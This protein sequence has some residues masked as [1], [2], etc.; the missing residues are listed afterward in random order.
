MPSRIFWITHT[1]AKKSSPTTNVMPRTILIHMPAKKPRFAGLAFFA[2]S[3]VVGASATRGVAPVLAVAAAAVSDAPGACSLFFAIA[4]L[5]LG[6]PGFEGFP[7]TKA[8]RLPNHERLPGVLLR[9]FGAE[10]I[11]PTPVLAKVL[12]YAAALS[13]GPSDCSG[14]WTS[15]GAALD[16]A[17]FEGFPSTKAQRLPNHE[18]L[19]GVLL[20]TFGAE[21]ISPTPVLA[22]VLA[23]TAALSVGPSDCS[24]V[25]TLTGAAFDLAAFEGFPS[26]RAQKPPSQEL[27]TGVLFLAGCAPALG[28]ASSGSDGLTGC[29]GLPS[30]KAHRVAG[31]DRFLGGCLPLVG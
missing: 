2:L 11:S 27:F 8:Q 17:G 9:T 3:G 10:E 22:P 20:R 1:T 5:D 6:L 30:I 25:W 19:P 31:I 29:G 4:G 15:T 28:T 21:E 23:F 13:V 14:V 24:G 26:M 18:R 12:A 7:S 16:V